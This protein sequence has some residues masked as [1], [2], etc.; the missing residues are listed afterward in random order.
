LQTH[1]KNPPEMQLQEKH[2]ILWINVMFFLHWII[3][4]K[5]L[6]LRISGHKN[7]NRH[8]FF[9]IQ[10]SISGIIHTI[11]LILLAIKNL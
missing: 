5:P 9:L 10:D 4:A 7:K 11:Y 6:F 2:N 3:F 8:S 1:L